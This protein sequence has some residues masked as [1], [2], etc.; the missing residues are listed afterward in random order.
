MVGIF[1]PSCRLISFTLQAW[2]FLAVHSASQDMGCLPCYLVPASMPSPSLMP[3]LYP[4]LSSYL[5]PV[6][7]FKAQLK[8]LAFDEASLKTPDPKP[9][10][11]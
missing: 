6:Q 8:S 11:I 10:L 3:F 2:S 5:N 4:L 9:T 7:A 1:S